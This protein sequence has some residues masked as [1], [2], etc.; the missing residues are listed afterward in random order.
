[1]TTAEARKRR[2]EVG[3]RKLTKEEL[4]RPQMLD[5]LDANKDGAVT[6]D[7]FKAHRPAGGDKVRRQGAKAKDAK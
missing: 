6:L 7:E 4:P 5:K 2:K 1:M 3:G